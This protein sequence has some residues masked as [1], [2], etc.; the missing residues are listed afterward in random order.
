MGGQNSGNIRMVRE[1]HDVQAA[2]VCDDDGVRTRSGDCLDDSGAVPVDE[3]RRA[4][5]AFRGPRL[6]EDEADFGRRGIDNVAADVQHGCR[7]P[8]RA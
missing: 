5:V 1:G 6:E 2:A 7:Q 3:Q 8:G 4:I